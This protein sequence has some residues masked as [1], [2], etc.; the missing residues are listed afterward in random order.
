MAGINKLVPI[1]FKLEGGKVNDPK[2]KGGATNMGVTIST[3]KSQG[4]DKDSD[5]DIDIQ[6]LW[7]ATKQDVINI[8][9]IYWDKWQADKIQN[10]SIANI[11]VDWVW[12]SGIWGI[13]IPQRLLGIQPDGIVGRLTISI[14]NSSNQKLLFDKIMIS[15]REFLLNIVKNNPTQE[16]FIKG[17][18]NRLNSFTFK[19]N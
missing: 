18:L 8:L 12:G 4:Y 17:W 11:L 2:D 10:Q 13:K 6:D 16:R 9:D 19:E 1:I 7:L 15:R 5:G 3:W 14:L